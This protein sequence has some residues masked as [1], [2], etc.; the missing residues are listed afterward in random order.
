MC[1]CEENG[2]TTVIG[3]DVFKCNFKENEDCDKCFMMAKIKQDDY[4]S[5]MKCEVAKSV[6][7]EYHIL[8]LNVSREK[9]GF[10]GNYINNKVLNFEINHSNRDMI[11]DSIWQEYRTD[12]IKYEEIAIVDNYYNVV[13]RITMRVSL[14]EINDYI[15][16]DLEGFKPYFSDCGE[17]DFVYHVQEVLGYKG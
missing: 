7:Y 15:Y 4:F 2:M 6:K 16:G 5:N 17:T 11:S 13:S 14:D 10:I 3:L 8:G 12:M 1:K 9:G